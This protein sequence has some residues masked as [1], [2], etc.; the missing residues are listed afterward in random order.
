MSDAKYAPA[1]CHIFQLFRLY[2]DQQ[3]PHSG[4]H[5]SASYEWSES[6]SSPSALEHAIGF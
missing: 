5:L 6:T 1:H 4:V 2:L 3:G